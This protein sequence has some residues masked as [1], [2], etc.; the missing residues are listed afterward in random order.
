MR[1]H[2]PDDDAASHISE[3]RLTRFKNFENA[4]IPLGRTSILTGRNSSGKSNILDALDV[5]HRL[6]N[7]EPLSDALDGR[8]REGGPVRGGASG[9]VPH[10]GDSFA[11]GCTVTVT[12][13]HGKYSYDYDVEVT[14]SP[15]PHIIQETLRGPQRAAKSGRWN[16]QVL[17]D[18]QPDSGGVG[19][20]AAVSSGRRGPNRRIHLR[21]DRSVLSQLPTVIPGSNRAERDILDA[22]RDISASLRRSFHFDPA[23]S[24]MRDWVPLR[25][26]RLRRSGENLAPILKHLKDQEPGTFSRLEQ[27]AQ[28]IADCDI[29]SLDFSSTDTGEIMLAIRERRGQEA[30]LTTARSMSDGL[31]RFLA[32]A[33][34]LSSPVSDLDLDALAPAYSSDVTAPSAGVLLAIEEIEN[35]LHPS[36]AGRLLHLINEATERINVN[37]LITTHSPALLDALSGDQLHD[38]LVCHHDQVSRLIDLPG[39]AQAMSGGRLGAVVTSGALEEAAHPGPDPDYSEFLSLIGAQ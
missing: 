5:L 11:L 13:P 6:T 2:G 23:P 8:R 1:K 14:P 19:L 18:A 34:A 24:L 35:G 15:F 26:A 32:I 17:I 12:H 9:C 20:E 4:T 3:L 22:Q 10:G 39:Y 21:D 29:D 7:A 16:Q 33:T 37:A 28:Q 25:G 30:S 27:L 36:Q 31:L 38:V